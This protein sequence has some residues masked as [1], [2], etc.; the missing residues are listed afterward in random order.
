[1]MSPEPKPC[2]KCDNR[3]WYKVKGFLWNREKI[4]KF[5]PAGE[6]LSSQRCPGYSGSCSPSSEDDEDSEN[7]ENNQ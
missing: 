2:V 4:C 3:G 6:L 5:C 1:M 7:Y